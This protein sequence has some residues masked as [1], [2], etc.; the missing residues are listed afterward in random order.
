M[1]PPEHF[2]G[3]PDH[4]AGRTEQ[5]R[6]LGQPHWGMWTTGTAKAEK[7]PHS[8]PATVPGETEA[9]PPKLRPLTCKRLLLRQH[10]PDHDGEAAGKS[11]VS[12]CE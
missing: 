11:Q 9:P 2:V 3:T 1:T 8:M 7:E 10:A 12:V 5:P 4:L 6:S